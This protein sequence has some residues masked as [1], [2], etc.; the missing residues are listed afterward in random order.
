MRDQRCRE[1][2][3]SRPYK[4]RCEEGFCSSRRSNLL[5]QKVFQFQGRLL[6]RQIQ[7]RRFATTST[8]KMYSREVKIKIP[9]KK[10]S[11]AISHKAVLF[12]YTT[13]LLLK[14][15]CTS[16]FLQGVSLFQA[17]SVLRAARRSCAGRAE[18]KILHNVFEV[19]VSAS[20]YRQLYR[21]NSS[22][23]THN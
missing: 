13:E 9:D 14:K 18:Q 5:F 21:G 22:S 6:H 23:H 1:V 15:L 3:I 10:N 20:H 8:H 16:V 11:L 4:C 7:E 17:L 12:I 2:K 19:P